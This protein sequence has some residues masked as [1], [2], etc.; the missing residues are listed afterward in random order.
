[1]E[2]FDLWDTTDGRHLATFRGH[3]GGVRGLAYRPDGRQI[4]SA[5][6]DGTVRLW[7]PETGREIRS[8]RGHPGGAFAVAFRPDGRQLASIGWD[9]T[10][11][12]WDP[13][14][15]AELRVLRGIVQLTTYQSHRYEFGNAVAF[16]PDGRRIASASD[17]GRVVVWD[18]ETGAQVL[19]LS[20]YNAQVNGVAFDPRGLRIA[21]ASID[22][23]IRLWDAV[24]GEE[25]FT[26]RGHGGSVLGVSFSPDGTQIATASV[27]MT[28]KIWESTRS[29]TDVLRKREIVALV[30]SLFERFPLQAE[31]IE[32]LRADVTLTPPA[33]ETALE[34]AAGQQEDPGDLDSA[35][36]KIAISPDRPSQEYDRA[37]RYAEA[38]NRLR[39]D[40]GTF[41][42]G[43]GVA[44][45][46]TGKYADAVETLTR[47]DPVFPAR[48]G[49]SVPTNLAFIAMAHHRLGHFPE[50]REALAQ[51]RNTMKQPQW[52]GDRESLGFLREAE[53]MNLD[54]MFPADPF[55]H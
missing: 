53:A 28:I 35:A 55:A 15:G 36:W 41:M 14:T 17:D 42:K 1:M 13:E 37:L 6:D 29:S 8:L 30:A 21:S 25:V 39:P 47:T 33:R 46:R 9:S 5:S 12:L 54:S 16:S 45:Y 51:L 49:G 20:G 3:D 22:G 23:T 48:A 26:L 18:T 44:Q 50:A 7:D 40:S 31:V 24:T 43:L 27:D 10:V 4:A 2:T 19:T 52:K 38:A 11:R 32:H 34:V